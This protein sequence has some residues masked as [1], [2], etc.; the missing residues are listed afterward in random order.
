[1]TF[2]KTGALPLAVAALL[3]VPT[4]VSA[5]AIQ[6]ACNASDRNASRALCSCIGD[7]AGDLLSGS[8]IRE[9]ARWFDDPQRAKMCANPTAPAM[10]R[11]GRLGE[12]FHRRHSNAADDP[13]RNGGSA[14]GQT[15]RPSAGG[16]FDQVQRPIEIPRI[17]R[18]GHRA[19]A[20]GRAE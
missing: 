20:S 9:G 12:P 6:R 4:T 8:Q 14:P 16:L 19:A 2:L 13:A 10:K 11:C 1:M 18:V 3:A 7:V 17:I 5:N 15:G